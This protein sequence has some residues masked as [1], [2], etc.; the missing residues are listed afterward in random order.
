MKNS[1]KWIGDIQLLLHCMMYKIKFQTQKITKPLQTAWCSSLMLR[2]PYTYW[3]GCQFMCWIFI[4]SGTINM[5]K[6][7]HNVR[8]FFLLPFLVILISGIFHKIIMTADGAAV[9][10]ANFQVPNRICFK[11]KRKDRRYN[12]LP[13]EQGFITS[14]IICIIICIACGVSTHYLHRWSDVILKPSHKYKEREKMQMISYVCTCC[15]NQ[16]I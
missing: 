12:N 1:L 8:V 16:I 14:S 5:G 7:Q 10:N 2:L 3:E 11:Q 9:L 6:T 4:E 15:I 13:L